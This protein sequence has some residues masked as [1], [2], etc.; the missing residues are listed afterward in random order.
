[1]K[2]KIIL[3]LLIFTGFKISAQQNKTTLDVDKRYH[4]FGKIK[5]DGGKVKAV[6]TFKN[7][8]NADLYILKVEP[9]CGCTLG[10]YTK[11]PIPPGKTGTVTAIFNPKNQ[12]GIIDKTV[13]VYTN[14]HYASIVVLEL[15]GEVIPRDKSMSDIFPY[16]VGNLMFDKEMVELGN[17]FHNA[18]DSAY[19]VMYNDGQYPIKINNV[20][21]LPVGYKVYA[22]KNAIEPNEEAKLFAVV[23]G[24]VIKDFG[25]FNKNFKL[26]TDDQEY[27][28]KPLFM[29]GS[30]QYNFGKMSKKQKKSSPKFSI[31]KKEK[32]FGEKAIGS[33]VEEFFYITNKGKND[34]EILTLRSQCS[35]TKAEIDKKTIKKGERAILKV[36]FDL[37]GHAGNIQ[38]P[39]T[40]YTNDPNNAEFNILLKAKL[41]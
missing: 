25:P 5:E 22:S 39:I 7:T 23:D 9:S 19:L 10:E 15:R 24:N 38:K 41:F 11:E 8:G 33:V 36:T 14:A 6:F 27:S 34:L 35:C 21:T 1:M 31:D 20:S 37:L 17:V 2:F 18:L 29:I 26:F 13:G 30:L 40:I 28:E 4:D 16:R 32:D 3:S 12:V